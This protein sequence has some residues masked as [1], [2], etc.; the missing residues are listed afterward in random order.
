MGLWGMNT[1]FSAD[2]PDKTTIHFIGGFAVIASD[3]ESEVAH[4]K[5]SSLAF[6][7]YSF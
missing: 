3:L 6:R 5:P 7:F 1:N 4:P 2:Y